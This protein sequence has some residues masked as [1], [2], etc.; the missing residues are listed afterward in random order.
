M[1]FVL[2]RTATLSSKTGH[3]I[4]FKEG[5]PT[6]VPPVLHKEALGFGAQPIDGEV[7]FEE[8]AGPVVVT[9]VEARNELIST[10]LESLR[11]KND[12]EDFTATGYPK[13]AA[14]KA[15][16]GFDVAAEE[17]KAL[18]EAVAAAA[19]SKQGA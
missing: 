15:L 14:V 18:W 9:D 7:E 8:P 4:E 5:E 10:V 16:T 17:V 12:P 2:N 3:S 13:V 19:A 6:Y 1:K 11:E